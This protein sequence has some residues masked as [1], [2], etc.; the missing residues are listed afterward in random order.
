MVWQYSILKKKLPLRKNYM[1]PFTLTRAVFIAACFIAA[2]LS[3]FDDFND[4]D[5][6]IFNIDAP[7]FNLKT[8]TIDPPAI[9]DI[10]IELDVHKLLQEDLFCQTHPLNKRSLLDLPIFIEPHD[11][12][13]DQSLGFHLFFN[14]TSRM[15]FSRQGS[16]ICTYL[17]IVGDT[18]LKKLE[19]AEDVIQGL[20][21]DFDTSFQQILPLFAD[22]VVQERRTGLMFHGH[23]SARWFNISFKVPF[24]YLERNFNFSTE[25][26]I[27]AIE[28]ALGRVSEQES[29]LFAKQH[30]ISDK[31]GIGDTRLMVDFKPGTK[32]N[33]SFRL[34]ALATLPT[35]L[36]MPHGII[37]SEFKKQ[38]T[39]PDRFLEKLFCLGQGTPEEQQV[40]SE[41][42]MN[43]ALNTLD[44]ISANILDTKLGNNGHLGLGAFLKTETPLAAFLSRKWAQ[45]LY[46]KS[47][48]SL[49]YLFPR[50]QL[51]YFVEGDDFALFEA[52][53]LNRSRDAISDDIAGDPE[54]GHE[55]FNF[56]EAQ[57]IDKFY[58]FV[59]KTR[60]NPRI[61][62]RSNTRM[63]YEAERWGFNL[64]TDMWI[65]GKEK[66]THIQCL[67]VDKNRP[68]NIDVA[69][70]TLPF[71]YQ[72]KLFG[73]ISF[74][75]PR[76]ECQ[77]TVSLHGD[78][79]WWSSGIGRDISL[80]IN[81]EGQF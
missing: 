46:F 29:M 19:T 14:Q 35:A 81:I 21:P 53:N 71:A 47:F 10:L 26:E 23:R 78:A 56:L 65:S 43:F 57:F 12:T 37:G 16:G 44:A 13:R 27:D 58:P 51:R 1:K 74:K 33:T 42:A 61:I 3:A 59:F 32:Y 60:V 52:L 49:E 15:F 69:K 62:Y 48:M 11:Y 18:L 38:T 2:P 63:V 68:A 5:F 28:N 34:G 67:R 6:D 9:A 31:L 76:E 50:T 30:L 72:S 7:H 64:G 80:A 77:W 39:R 73:C 55:V 41:L 79:T 22:A 54:Y 75:I 25:E 24:Y 36:T 40:A 17:N 45:P 20:Y 4:D 8:P 70:A 66:L